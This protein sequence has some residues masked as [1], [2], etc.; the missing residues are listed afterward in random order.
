MKAKGGKWSQV[1][2]RLCLEYG[3]NNLD[4]CCGELEQG[5]RGGRTG[6]LLGTLDDMTDDCW[7]TGQ[8]VAICLEIVIF[9]F[10]FSPLLSDNVPW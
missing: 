1:K 4:S 5:A 8:N 2:R 3:N 7:F 9:L 10:F 6:F